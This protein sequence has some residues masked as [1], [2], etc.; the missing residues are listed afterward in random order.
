MT[1]THPPELTPLRPRAAQIVA[2]ARELLE[3]FGFEAITMRLLADR[4][5]MRAPSLYKHMANKAALKV[6]LVEQGLVELGGALHASLTA[7]DPIREL[8][9]AYRAYGLSHPNLYRLGTSGRLPRAE[10][11]PNL[12]EW[13]GAP[14]FLVTEDVHLGQALWSFAHGMVILELDDRY[15]G[16]SDLEKTWDA[17]AAAFGNRRP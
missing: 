17:G 16:G 12:E 3:E 13:A 1:L 5:G 15:W 9:R 7:A 14:F 10:L 8:L 2:V 4:V 11:A 6:A